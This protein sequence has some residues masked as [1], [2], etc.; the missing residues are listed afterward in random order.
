M[1]LEH[2]PGL[3]WL[4]WFGYQLIHECKTFLPWSYVEDT[5]DD[6]QTVVKDVSSFPVK[7]T[8]GKGIRRRRISC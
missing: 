5:P 7:Q 8:G 3:T 6:S 1:T 4:K 2:L